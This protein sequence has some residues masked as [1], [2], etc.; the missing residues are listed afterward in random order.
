M[1]RRRIAAVRSKWLTVE[2]A[3]GLGRVIII[4]ALMLSIGMVVDWAVDLEPGFRTLKVKEVRELNLLPSLERKQSNKATIKIE[5]AWWLT[6]N[7]RPI[8]LFDDEK[9]WRDTT[10]TKSL[11]HLAD[12][13]RPPMVAVSHGMSTVGAARRD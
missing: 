10:L 4:L 6:H 9:V 11:N 12:E 3:G 1:L 7:L 8:K 5:R 2:V 13:I